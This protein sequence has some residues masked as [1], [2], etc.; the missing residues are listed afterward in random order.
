MPRSH[1]PNL[2]PRYFTDSIRGK[3][4]RTQITYGL[5]NEGFR[6]FSMVIDTF[7]RHVVGWSMANHM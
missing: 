4:W 2:V 5:T 3:P 1:A 7:C 6:S